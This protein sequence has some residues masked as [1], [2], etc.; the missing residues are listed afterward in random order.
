MEDRFRLVTTT[1]STGSA[2]ASAP[3][4]RSIDWSHD[5]LPAEERALF[6]RLSIFAGGWTLEAAEAVCAG[7]AAGRR[8]DRAPRAAWSRSRS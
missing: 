3:C 5:L 8:R 6:H 2:S 1:N 4:A 7:P